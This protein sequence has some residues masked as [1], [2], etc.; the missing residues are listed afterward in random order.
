[1][2]T[3]NRC[4]LSHEQRDRNKQEVTPFFVF[5]LGTHIHQSHINRL[6]MTKRVQIS[7]KNE[8]LINENPHQSQSFQGLN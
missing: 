7:T 6:K 5:S 3:T 1:L 2:E 4:F 8:T